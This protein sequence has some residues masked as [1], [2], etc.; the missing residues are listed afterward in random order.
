M[1]NLFLDNVKKGENSW[2]RYLITTFSSWVLSSILAGILF[3]LIIVSYF[4]FS[5][6]LNSNVIINTMINF[7]SNPTVFFLITFLSFIIST[8]IFFI[9]VKYLHKRNLLSLVNTSKGK[10]SSGKSL[11]WIKRVR[12]K[13]IIKGAVIWLIFLSIVEFI[14]YVY[15]PNSFII[16]F[17]IENISLMILLFIIAIP[18]QVTFEEL[19]FRGYIN[20]A[21]SLKIKQPLL[22]ILISSLIFSIGHILNGG[23]NLIFMIENVSITFIVGIILSGFTL[24]DNGIELAIGAHLANNFFAFIITSSE[25]SLGNFNTIIQIVGIDPIVEL[26]FSIISILIFAFIL[27]LYKKEDVLKA[28]N[29]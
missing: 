18:I 1:S 7:E 5:G 21:I 20:Q 25:G 14:L 10:D 11:S 15:A 23:N 22:I 16:N 26:L 29:I 3:G 17:N 28:L 8:L 6:N 12:W 19:F 4:I 13:K 27:F 9:C 24:V 2:F